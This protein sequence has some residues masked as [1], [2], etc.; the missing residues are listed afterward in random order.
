MNNIKFQYSDDNIEFFMIFKGAKVI[1]L[2]AK[3]SLEL[4]QV[5]K[6]R[7]LAQVEATQLMSVLKKAA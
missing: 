1:L 2:T 5:K 4:V 3:A 6:L 7:A